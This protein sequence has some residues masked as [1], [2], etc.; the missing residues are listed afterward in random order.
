M[1]D[2]TEIRRLLA[3]NRATVGASLN[4]YWRRWSEDLIA[5]KVAPAKDVTETMLAVAT[6][7]IY[8]I[9]GAT[10]AAAALRLQADVLDHAA[11]N[12][13]EYPVTEH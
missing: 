13:C 7:Q 2:R 9:Y 1:E 12:G 11:A 10:R 3:E 5:A 8:K 6:V 4:D